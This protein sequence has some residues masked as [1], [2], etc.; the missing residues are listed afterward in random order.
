MTVLM[1]WRTRRAVAGRSCQT[2]RSV[3]TTSALVTSE[4]G[5][6]PSRG[7]AKR[8]MLDSQSL[9]CLGLRQPGRICARTASAAAAKVGMLLRRRFSASGSPPARASLRLASAAA[10]ASLSGTSGKPP[11]PS[12]RRLP[13][14]TSRCT[15]LRVPVGCTSR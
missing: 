1:R 7:K 9:P 12:S 6:L 4:T 14:M 3:S 11:S 8:S 13:R 10:R 15:Q 2:L 5:S